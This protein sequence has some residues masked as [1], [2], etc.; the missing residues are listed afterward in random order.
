MNKHILTVIPMKMKNVEV[1][2]LLVQMTR[3]K[4]VQMARMKKVALLMVSFVILVVSFM[5]FTVYM[6][7]AQHYKQVI[8]SG[9]KLIQL[10]DQRCH[11]AGCTSQ[12]TIRYGITCCCLTINAVCNNGHVYRWESSDVLVSQNPN[13]LYVDNLHFASTL[14]LS[15][16]NYKKIQLFCNFL[17]VQ[18]IS[19]TTF[20]S[21]QRHYI[22]PGIKSYYEEEQV[23]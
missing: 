8:C 13:K 16:N 18:I 12:R 20:H 22:C 2:K 19:N 7:T 14:V 23:H 15:G 1:T 10:V 3:M 4:L 9:H 11:E 5:V 6:F 17:G 21:Y